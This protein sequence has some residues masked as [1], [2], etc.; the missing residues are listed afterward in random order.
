MPTVF[1]ILIILLS[2]VWQ[3]QTASTGQLTIVVRDEVGLPLPGVQVALFYDADE[4]RQE[5]GA[6]T[7][8]GTG[9]IILNHLQWGLYVVQFRGTLPDG[10]PIQAAD[11]QNQGLLDDGQGVTNGFGVRFAEATRTELFVL[12]RPTPQGQI[13]PLFDLAPDVAAAPQPFSPHGDAGIPAGVGTSPQPVDPANVDVAI[14][15]DASDAATT[16]EAASAVPAPVDEATPLNLLSVLLCLFP[17][18]LVSVPITLGW[19]RAA[20]AGRHH[21][22]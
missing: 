19:F 15:A 1:C 8:D 11:Q 3:A 12:T 6:Y 22:R 17:V 7:T 5:I 4:G 14:P 10:Q 20:Q 18:L 9:R 2:P 21:A 13:V 16:V